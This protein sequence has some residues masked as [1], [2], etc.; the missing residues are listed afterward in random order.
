MPRAIVM[1]DTSPMRQA[2][3]SAVLTPKPIWPSGRA[4][5]FVLVRRSRGS[6]EKSDLR[7]YSRALSN[8]RLANGANDLGHAPSFIVRGLKQLHIEFDR[9]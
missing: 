5:T 7:R 6:R 4:F 1:R 9:A 2:L 3:T 8:I